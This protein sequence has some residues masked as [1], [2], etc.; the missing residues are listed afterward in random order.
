M[1]LTAIAWVIL[2]GLLA[3]CSLHRPVWAVSLYMLTFFAAPHLWWWGDQ[4][5]EARYA[6]VAGLVPFCAVVFHLGQASEGERQWSRT[7]TAALLIVGNA[8]FVHFVI[9]ST[10]SVS[11]DHYVELLKF[12]LLF[13][14]VWLAIQDRRDLRIAVIAIA[15]GAAYIGYEVT[16]NERGDFSGSRLEGVGAPG[17][18]SSNSLASVMLLTLPLIGTLWVDG[19]KRHKLTAISPRRSPSTSSFSATAAAPSSA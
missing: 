5:P 14:L 17:A 16:I 3:V 19:E 9:A 18:D 6:L 8:T 2:F 12:I 1:S 11:V 10:P 15:L 4:I 13:F 7:H